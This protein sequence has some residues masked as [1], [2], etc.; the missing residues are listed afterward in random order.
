MTDYTTRQL[1]SGGGGGGGGIH[2]LTPR[3]SDI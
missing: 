2:I 3:L 1:L